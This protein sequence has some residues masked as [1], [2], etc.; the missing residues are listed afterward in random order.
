[1]VRISVTSGLS[2]SHITIAI[3]G[4]KSLTTK[5]LLIW[6]TEAKVTVLMMMVQ[7]INT[8]AN[9]TSQCK[10]SEMMHMCFDEGE[11]LLGCYEGLTFLYV[12]C[13]CK[14]DHRESFIR[15]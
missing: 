3:R 11:N 14:Q 12:C 5:V 8:E 1:M 15:A 4:I 10:F 13:Y 9:G 6:V 7:L 2:V